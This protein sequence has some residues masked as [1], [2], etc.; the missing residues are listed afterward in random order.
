MKIIICIDDKNGMMFNKR[1]Q[2]K[3]SAVRKDISEMVT[4]SRIWMNAYS[5]KQFY[6]ESDRMNI[7][8]DEGFMD[9]AE[10]DYCFVENILL[11][12]YISQIQQIIIYYWNRQYP[13]DL[14]FDIDVKTSDW[15]MIQQKQFIGTSH[16]KIRKEIY[17]QKR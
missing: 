10:N 15:E 6:S 17:I 12:P 14:F 1:R 2:T 13:A 16:D 8:I 7:A 9:K 3:D 5:A 11:K 4:T